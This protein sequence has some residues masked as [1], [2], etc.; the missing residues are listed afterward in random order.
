MS[1]LSPRKDARFSSGVWGAA[2]PSEGAVLQKRSSAVLSRRSVASS[3]ATAITTSSSSASSSSS[4]LAPKEAAALL[5]RVARLESVHVDGQEYQGCVAGSEVV[6]ALMHHRK[7]PRT[8]ALETARLLLSSGYLASIGSK[9]GF[10]D[11]PDRF[12]SFVVLPEQLPS[13]GSLEHG[14]VQWDQP[15]PADMRPFDDVRTLVASVLGS[16][17]RFDY[18]LS[19]PYAAY[20][21][22]VSEGEQAGY[23]ITRRFSDLTDLNRLLCKKYFFFLLRSFFLVFLKCLLL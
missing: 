11:S 18:R 16:A 7:S 8:E 15:A 3:S 4:L 13:S 20:F 14:V 21:V 19:A 5:R 2:K 6:L 10:A 12:Y 1:R 9:T 22:H 17:W 23:T